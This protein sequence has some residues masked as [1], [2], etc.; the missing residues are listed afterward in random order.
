MTVAIFLA[1]LSTTQIATSSNAAPD[2]VA[3]DP[4]E[5]DI[6]RLIRLCQFPPLKGSKLCKSL[7]V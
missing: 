1:I 4:I 5:D 3:H 2:I 6:D 7:G